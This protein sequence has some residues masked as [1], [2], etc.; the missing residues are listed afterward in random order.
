M[1][2]TELEQQRVR[3]VKITNGLEVPFTDRHDGVPITICLLY[4][5]EPPLT[6]LLTRFTG[7]SS[8]ISGHS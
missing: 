7:H 5:S 4:T 3:Y 6:D 2:P 1:N 8:A